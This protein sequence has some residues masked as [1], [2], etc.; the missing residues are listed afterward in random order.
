[1]LLKEYI[2][3][4]F[5]LKTFILQKHNFHFQF[6]AHYSPF[7]KLTSTATVRHQLKLPRRNIPHYICCLLLDHYVAVL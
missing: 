3:N 4:H 5:G 2:V 7:G 6:F 1:M